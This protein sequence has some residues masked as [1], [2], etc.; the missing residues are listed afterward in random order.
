MLNEVVL[1]E[2]E[3]KDYILLDYGDNIDWGIRDLCDTLNSIEYF[4]TTN[5]C[6]GSLYENEKSN[7]CPKTYVDFYVLDHNYEVANNLFISL[8]S[9]FGE[10]LNCTL[11]FQPDFDIEDEYSEE[12]G[13]VILRYRIEL[14]CENH[15]IEDNKNTI[16]K[17]VKFIKKYNM[18]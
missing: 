5:S 11:N 12:N 16:K 4:V 14:I 18:Q 6:Q 1:L 15:R 13:N 9:E 2:Y 3:N 7:H 10:H 17:L 8:I